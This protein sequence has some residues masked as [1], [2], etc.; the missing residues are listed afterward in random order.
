MV[1]KISNLCSYHTTE[2]NQMRYNYTLGIL[3]TKANENKEWKSINVRFYMLCLKVDN[4][5]IHEK[6]T[7]V[8]RIKD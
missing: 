3:S 5:V 4:T 8:T 2:V 1:I 6:N 7:I